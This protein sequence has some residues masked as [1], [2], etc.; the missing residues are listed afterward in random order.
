MFREK[1]FEMEGNDL[2]A[3][4]VNSHSQR[5]TDRIWDRARDLISERYKREKAQDKM[6]DS[7]TAFHEIESREQELIQ[8]IRTSG[9]RK[10]RETFLVDEVMSIRTERRKLFTTLSKHIDDLT[11]ESEDMKV[12]IS[13]FD[14]KIEDA[15]KE[16]SKS[17]SA[18]KEDEISELKTELEILKVQNSS[19]RE[20][21]VNIDALKSKYEAQLS[22]LEAKIKEIDLQRKKNTEDEAKALAEKLS[23]KAIAEAELNFNN[24]SKR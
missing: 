8:H 19:K 16:Y 12:E 6:F 17:I 13:S 24:N 9:L 23:A 18:S 11:M 3:L 5:N 7:S 4:N 21:K 1:K 22:L 20:T 15:L 10:P 2:H 14:R